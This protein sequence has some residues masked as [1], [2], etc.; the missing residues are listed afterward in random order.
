MIDLSNLLLNQN[1]LSQDLC[2]AVLLLGVFFPPGP[3]YVLQ[4]QITS[5]LRKGNQRCIILCL[6]YMDWHCTAKGSFWYCTVC[7]CQDT[8]VCCHDRLALYLYMSLQSVQ[9]Y[10]MSLCIGS[11]SSPWQ[12]K[13]WTLHMHEQSS[14]WKGFCFY[15]WRQE[16]WPKK[17]LSW[18][19]TNVLLQVIPKIE[20]R[21]TVLRIFEFSPLTHP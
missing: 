1:I 18:Q 14:P 11:T 13:I 9:V 15:T 17:S 20:P 19:I 7:R 6:G 4:V 5:L 21:H 12:I 3:L 16:L 8:A 10:C 2:L